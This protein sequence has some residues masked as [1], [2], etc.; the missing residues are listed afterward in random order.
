MKMRQKSKKSIMRTYLF[1]DNFLRLQ[2]E[3]EIV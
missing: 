1:V 2:E 3:D